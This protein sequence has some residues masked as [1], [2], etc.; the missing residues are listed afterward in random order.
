MPISGMYSKSITLDF[1]TFYY[2]HSALGSV[3]K[4][5]IPNAHRRRQES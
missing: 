3:L 2:T 1:S 4:H 5:R